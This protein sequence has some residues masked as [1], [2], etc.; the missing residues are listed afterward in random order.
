MDHI[1]VAKTKIIS[2]HARRLFCKP[3]CIGVKIKLKN[4]FNIKGKRTI[5]GI[6]FL[7]NIKNTF[8]KEKAIS[9]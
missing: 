8:P 2:I 3:N 1:K 9:K 4:K 5:N 6:C 7:K